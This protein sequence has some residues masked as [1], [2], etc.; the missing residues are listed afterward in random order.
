MKCWK[1]CGTMPFL[2]AVAYIGGLLLKSLSPIHFYLNTSFAL[3]YSLFNIHV[4]L[5]SIIHLI[6]IIIGRGT[7]LIWKCYAA[8]WNGM[9]VLRQWRGPLR[10]EVSVLQT[11]AQESVCA[12]SKHSKSCFIQRHCIVNLAYLINCIVISPANVPCL[13]PQCLPGESEVQRSECLS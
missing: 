4:G 3:T 6:I 1:L 5:R 8:V 7:L 13:T 11:K 9:L 12:H 10:K 2:K